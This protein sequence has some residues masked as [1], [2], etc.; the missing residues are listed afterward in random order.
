MPLSQRLQQLI[1]RLQILEKHFLPQQFSLSG[2][3]SREQD[4]RT[5]AYLLLVHAELEAYL[6]DRARSRV[7][8]AYARWQRTGMCTPVLSRLLVYHQDEFEP[9]SAI[10][11]DKAVNFYLDKVDKNHG[12]KQKNLLSLFLPLGIS[13]QDLDTQ[14]MSACE[15]LGRKRGQFAHASIK[16]H[17]QVDPKTERDNIKK[18]IIPEL[19]KLDRKLKILR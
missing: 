19:K 15:Q 5:K 8:L 4:D 2:N 14:L 17:Q 12:I 3:Y 11:V 18:N 7:D 9:I 13:H 1:S 10:K 16:T 6:E